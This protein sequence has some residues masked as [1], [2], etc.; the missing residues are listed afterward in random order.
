MV[1]TESKGKLSLNF[2]YDAPPGLKREQ[3][4]EGDKAEPRFEWQRKYQ[5]PRESW[6][7]GNEDIRDQPFGIQVRNVKCLKC[8]K[9]GHINT[10]RECP[11]YAETQGVREKKE[12]TQDPIELMLMMQEEQKLRLKQGAIARG[13]DVEQEM[14]AENLGTQAEEEE[15]LRRMSL[16]DKKK[17]L[18]KLEKLERKKQKKN[19][20]DKKKKKDRKKEKR[21]KKDKRNKKETRERGHRE[22]SEPSS[23]SVSDTGAERLDP[24]SRK[25]S[26]SPDSKSQDSIRS[27]AERVARNI[28]PGSSDGKES[29]TRAFSNRRDGL[30]HRNRQSPVALRR[31]S[32]SPRDNRQISPM[33][34]LSDGRPRKIRD[35]DE[36]G[37]QITSPKV[38]GYSRDIS[39]KLTIRTNLTKNDL[40][41]QR[42]EGKNYSKQRHLPRRFAHF[43]GA[44]R[45]PRRV[46]SRS[47]VRRSLSPK[48]QRKINRTRPSPMRKQ[49]FSKKNASSSRSLSRSPLRGRSQSSDVDPFNKAYRKHK[50]SRSTSSES[51][52][53][54]SERRFTSPLNIKRRRHGSDS[55]E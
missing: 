39:P 8:G 25:R 12:V 18:K 14:V 48:R 24:A 15:V 16:K 5:A 1:S 45:S 52:S 46:R 54:P 23:T 19:K 43:K 41:K 10:D 34:S 42:Y 28:I 30:L 40:R 20:K 55:D 3:K 7:K 44:E 2:M 47:P 9:W 22:N 53:G 26:R 17:L 31:L 6:A 33:P 51:Q 29:A 49:A 35:G 27:S 50:P 4:D 13:L 11:R 32:R 21:A 36:G 38:N 37:K